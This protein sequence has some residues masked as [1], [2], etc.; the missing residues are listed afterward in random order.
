MTALSTISRTG[1]QW[2][3]LAPVIANFYMEHF[4]QKAVSTAIKKPARWYRYVD[5]IFAV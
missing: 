3:P 2:V 1:L 5:D 4:E